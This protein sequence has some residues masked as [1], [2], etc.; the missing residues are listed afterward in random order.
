MLPNFSLPNFANLAALRGLGGF[1]PPGGMPVE[2]GPVFPSPVWG[3]TPPP[4]RPV[5]PAYPAQPTSG[6]NPVGPAPV[7]PGGGGF[8][9][10]VGPEPVR[11]VGPAFPINPGAGN[12]GNFGGANFDPNMLRNLMALRQMQPY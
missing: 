6:V 4:V 8:G 10:G 3:G 12:F 11:P 1:R 9:G 2:G 7:L 5:G